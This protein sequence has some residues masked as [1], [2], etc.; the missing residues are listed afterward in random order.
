M[1]IDVLLIQACGSWNEGTSKPDFFSVFRQS[2]IGLDIIP[3]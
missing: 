1:I 2:I 3:G